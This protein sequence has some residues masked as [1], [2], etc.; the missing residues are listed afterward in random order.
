MHWKHHEH[1]RGSDPSDLTLVLTT[2]HFVG[3][4]P[5]PLQ[6]LGKIQPFY[7]LPFSVLLEPHS[8][9]YQRDKQTGDGSGCSIQGVGEWEWL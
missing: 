6:S 8:V 2:S 1:L 9:L 7:L 5:E 3:T 4:H